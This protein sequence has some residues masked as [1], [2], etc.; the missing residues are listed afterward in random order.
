MLVTLFEGRSPMA[1]A[2]FRHY[3][4]GISRLGKIDS[5]GAGDPKYLLPTD[6]RTLRTLLR[7][8]I[9]VSWRNPRPVIPEDFTSFQYIVGVD[10]YTLNRLNQ[11]QESWGAAG[12]SQI[13]LLGEFGESGNEEV[14]D[15]YYQGESAFEELF[16]QLSSLCRNL[17]RRISKT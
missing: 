4:K 17:L 3:A 6:G 13:Q 10:M 1:E 12:S 16:F 7:H 14:F 5:A 8:K 9:D 11:L 2:I 15:P